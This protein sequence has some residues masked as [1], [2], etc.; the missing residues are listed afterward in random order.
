MHRP[1]RCCNVQDQ[2]TAIWLFAYFGYWIQVWV[3]ILCKALSGSLLVAGVRRKQLKTPPKSGQEAQLANSDDSIA[4]PGEIP[5][6]K[7]V[8]PA[9]FIV[10][11]ENVQHKS[12]VKAPHEEEA[13]GSGSSGSSG[14]PTHQH[15][16][17]Q[18]TN[19]Q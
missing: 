17:V 8:Q 10:H 9:D 2:G 14:N 15:Q 1:E 18:M 12:Q 13:E 5:K 7:E 16:H 6:G 19:L 4:Q 3:V 11:H